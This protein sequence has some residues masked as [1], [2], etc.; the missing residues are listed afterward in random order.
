MLHPRLC[1]TIRCALETRELRICGAQ[2]VMKII[3]TVHALRMYFVAPECIELDKKK[4]A[5]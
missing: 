2:A 4:I 1:F 3:I 5:S